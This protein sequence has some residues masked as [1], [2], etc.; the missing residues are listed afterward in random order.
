MTNLPHRAAG[1][2]GKKP[3]A[4]KSIARRET[5]PYEQR[6]P[7]LTP[8]SSISIS[9][10]CGNWNWDGPHSSGINSFPIFPQPCGTSYP[11]YYPPFVPSPYN[12]LPLED[13][14]NHSFPSG[15]SSFV[16]SSAANG[17]QPSRNHP[18]SEPFLVK[19]LNG[20]MKIC[21]GCKG[22][23]LKNTNNR[24]LSPP[25]DICICHKETQG[26]INPQTGLE[27][28]KLGNAYYHVNLTCIQKKHPNFS[29]DQLV[30]P[31]DVQELLNEAHVLL[32]KEA[33]GYTVPN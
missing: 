25:Y 19:L 32:L 3:P 26:F 13:I 20:R 28:S 7:L 12:P 5:T 6:Q 9:T 29:P 11:M 17:A 30:C 1:R 21:A 23:H 4:K 22:P 15:F 16:H 14:T 33:L 27:S 8:S 24:V 10:S 2:K 18:S 31:E